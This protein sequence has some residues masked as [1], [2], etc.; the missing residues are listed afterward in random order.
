MNIYQRLNE[1]RKKV[2]Y[3]RKDAKVQGYKAVTHDA[4]TSEVRPHLIENGVMIVPRLRESAY[5]DT[6]TTTG[7]GTPW[8]RYEA[9]Y[10]ID[11]VN[12]DSPEDHITLPI[13][14][15][16]LDQGDKAPG[17]AMSYAVKYALLKVLNIE[18]GENEEG[19]QEMKPRGKMNGT[20]LDMAKIKK[21]A[22]YIKAQ[23][24]EDDPDAAPHNLK[25]AWD[26]LNNDERLE[27]QEWLTDKA[28]D[29]NRMYKTLLKDYLNAAKDTGEAP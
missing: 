9:T 2:E 24:D 20:D 16:A 11:F 19:R 21:A 23:I 15:H 8:M 28:P 22:N 13:E 14:S 27:V 18:T 6:G 10:E 5:I 26:R 12:I 25:K 4:V 17:K 29:T 7:S 3:I 1:V